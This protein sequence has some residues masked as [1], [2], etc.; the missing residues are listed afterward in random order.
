M[1]RTAPLVFPTSHAVMTRSAS[2][3]PEAGATT[4]RL[5][6]VERHLQRM[7]RRL[8]A[9]ERHVRKVDADCTGRHD[10][11]DRVLDDR[12]DDFDAELDQRIADTSEEGF[13]ALFD[14]RFEAKLDER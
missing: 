14:A 6:A 3:R 12:L 10:A 7:H 11:R 8:E 4:R 5:D 13:D 2:A 9:S 1:E